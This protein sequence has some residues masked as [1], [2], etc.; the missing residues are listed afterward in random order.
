MTRR[1]SST[2]GNIC[3]Y[4]SPLKINFS[5]P[6]P[7]SP[8]LRGKNR[9]NS[10]FVSSG[11][12]HLCWSFS[13]SEKVTFLGVIPKSWQASMTSYLPYRKISYQKGFCLS[14]RIEEFQSHN[15]GQ[16]VLGR[17]FFTWFRL[18]FAA[19]WQY[20][21]INTAL[22]RFSLWFTLSERFLKYPMFKNHLQCSK[23]MQWLVNQ[24]VLS[25]QKRKDT[26]CA[27]I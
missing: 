6:H 1:F 18:E 19:N 12:F 14:W 9:K 4:P 17:L 5:K 15:P 7:L 2:K 3:T 11:P 8:G 24:I 26:C 20:T 22:A 27:K 13:F 10:N 23:N 16:K 25:Q 21:L